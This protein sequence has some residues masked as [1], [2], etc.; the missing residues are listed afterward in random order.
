MSSEQFSDLWRRLALAL[1]DDDTVSA[2]GLMN[3][4]HD[5][6][7]SNWKAIS[8]AAVSAIRATGDQRLLLIAGDQWS[9]AHEFEKT[10]GKAWINDPL[11]HIAYEAHCY[12]DRDG[13]GRYELSYD[14]E[15]LADSKFEER[16]CK[17]LGCFIE[18]CR[19]NNVKGFI[20]EYAVP[21]DDS[22]WLPMLERMQAAMR[23]AGMEGAY[24]GGGEWWGAHRLSIQPTDGFTRHASPVE[25]LSRGR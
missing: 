4:P 18:W 11:N 14:G 21:S 2:F 13:S 25:V 9:K 20:G 24:W 10:N 6:G 12:L 3:E 15:R 8:Q 22:R 23:E 17:R 1:R 16:A 5:M 7:G 19:A